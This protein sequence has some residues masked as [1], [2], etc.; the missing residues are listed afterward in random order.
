MNLIVAVAI[1]LLNLYVE[2]SASYRIPCFVWSTDFLDVAA[3]IYAGADP[4]VP[5]GSPFYDRAF[6]WKNRSRLGQCAGGCWD[7][8]DAAKLMIFS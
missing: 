8:F 5:H 1:V 7:T 2:V 6:G 4:G 3:S